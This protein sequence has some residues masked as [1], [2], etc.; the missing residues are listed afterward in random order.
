MITRLGHIQF[1]N[2]L[3]LYYGMLRER[4]TLPVE[5]VKGTPAGLNQRLLEGN[6]DIGPISSLEYGEN[7]ELLLLLPDISVS[8]DGEV[9][10][11]LILSKV[12][13]ARL[14]GKKVALADTSATSQVLAKIILEKKYRVKPVYYECPPN[15]T[16]MLLEA[17]AALLIGDDALRGYFM[18]TGLN[19]IDL[20]EEWL[21]LTGEKMVYAVWAVRRSFASSAQEEVRKVYAI[22]RAS[23]EYSQSH[24]KEIVENIARYEVFSKEF[25]TEY[26]Q[27]LRFNFDENYQRGLLQFFEEARDLG[28]MKKSPQLKF[29]S[30]ET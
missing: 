24:L 23:L 22:L 3:P 20:G 18:E 10:S 13:P 26:F 16:E 19:K 29:F 1:L 9:K 30:V 11:I 28:L 8:S 6:I 4:K 27:G 12:P 5:L 15:L 2:C 25:L 14:G 17:D 7:Y 21:D